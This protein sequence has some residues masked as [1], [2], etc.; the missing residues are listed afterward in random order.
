MDGDGKT[1]VLDVAREIE[2]ARDIITLSTGVRGRIRPV[3]AGLIDEVVSR[4]PDPEVPR[5][6]IEDKGRE[7]LNPFDPAYIEAVAKARAVRPKE[8]QTDAS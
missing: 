5:Q 6:F 2:P 4:I 8:S 1:P 3:P 7:E